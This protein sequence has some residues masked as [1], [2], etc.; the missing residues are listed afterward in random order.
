MAYYVLKLDTSVNWILELLMG[1]CCSVSL[2]P[3]AHFAKSPFLY[4]L[5]RRI[6]RR[7]VWNLMQ[8][9]AALQSRCFLPLEIWSSVLARSDS[10]S[11]HL[12]PAETFSV[13][14]E[15]ILITCLSHASLVLGNL[16]VRGARFSSLVQ[17]FIQWNIL[18]VKLLEMGLLSLRGF[19]DME[20]T[21]RKHTYGWWLCYTAGCSH[22][23][24]SAPS[25]AVSSLHSG[26]LLLNLPQFPY[27][28][29][30]LLWV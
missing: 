15:A 27:L 11:Y 28:Y 29:M 13:V 21:G 17:T 20:V 3:G 30:L 14:K 24:T 10:C 25:S 9:E 2:L 26:P 1:R 8:E 19:S 22:S 12:F 4:N 16:Y 7:W 18:C 23:W 6:K 5:T